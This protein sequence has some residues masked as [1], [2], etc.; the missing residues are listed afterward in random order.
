VEIK[1]PSNVVVIYHEN[2]ADGFTAAWVARG[3]FGDAARYIPCSYGDD[4]PGGLDGKNVYI[5]DFSFSREKLIKLSESAARLVVLDHHKT[6]QAELS[7]LEFAAFDMNKS[8]ASMAWEY[9]N[10][11]KEKPLLIRYVEDRDLWRNSLPNCNEIRAVIES[12]DFD[13]NA[14]DRLFFDM[15]LRLESVVESGRS[16]M[17]YKEFCI[18]TLMKKACDM[19]IDGH[20]VPS[21]NS[22]IWQ[23]E[24]GNWLCEMTDK[25]SCV[26]YRNEKGEH[27][28]SLRSTDSLMDVSAV[29]KNLGGGGHRNAAGFKSYLPPALLIEQHKPL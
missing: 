23:S 12:T 2:C 26:W 15:S 28:Y 10:T 13:F 16:M 24:I 29:A 22:P 27:I 21:V 19:E 20:I 14:F 7:D 11:G 6:A 8:G 4:V 5:L 17:K 25:F 18:R 9:F 1:D 3:R